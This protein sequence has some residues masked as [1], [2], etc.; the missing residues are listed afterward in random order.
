MKH[1]LASFLG[2][3]LGLFLFALALLV[4]HRTLGEFRYHDIAR[5]LSSIPPWHIWMAILLTILNYAILTGYDILALKYIRR[6][7]ETGKTI[8][9]SFISYAFSQSLGFG[10]LT[11]GSLRFRLYSA[12][13]LSALEITSIVTFC[14]LTFWIG[15]LT[16]GGILFLIENFTL[17][18]DLHLPFNSIYPIGL[19]FLSLTLSYLIWSIFGKKPL[20]IRQWEFAVP[21]LRISFLQIAIA[22]TDWAVAGAVL[23]ALLPSSA[24]V[25]YP[26]LLGIFILAQVIGLISH[27]PGGL[28]IFEA[29]ILTALSPSIP[30]STIMASL[31]AYRIIYYLMPL[32]IGT[33]ALGT[34]EFL[35]TR[36]GPRGITFVAERLLPATMPV[37]LGISTFIGGIILLISGATPSLGHRLIFLRE[38]IPLPIIEFSHFLGSLIG[39]GLLFLAWGVHR[40]IDAAYRAT[41]VLLVAGATASLLKGGDYEEAFILGMMFFAF[42]PCAKHFHRRSALFDRPLSFS[43]IAAIA[44]TIIGS[45]W[46][47]FFSY[48]HVDYSNDL[49]WKFALHGDAPRFLRASI[50]VV[51]LAMAISLLRLL[52]PVA[53]VAIRTSI[54]ELDRVNDVVK[55]SPYT[56]AH[57][58]N[59]GDK[60]FLFSDSGKAFIMYGVEGRSWVALGDPIGLQSDWGDLIWRFRDLCDPYDGWP[61]FYQVKADTLYR[62]MDLG[63]TMQKLGEEARVA[64]R[65]F[66]LDKLKKTLRHSHRRVEKEGGTFEILQPPINPS[67]M[68]R[69]KSISDSWLSEKNTHEKGFSLGFFNE[70]YLEKYPIAIVRHEGAIVAF[71]NVWMG[72]GKHE[73]SIDLMR[74]QPDA[75]S[76]LIDFLFISLMQWGKN[77]GYSWFNLGM[78]PLSGLEQRA[79]APL[80]NRMGALLYRT[81]EHF[82]NFQGLRAYKEKFNPV[83]EPRYLVSPGGLVL[84]RIL[85]NI[86]TLISGGLKGVVSK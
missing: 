65:S 60:R 21:S 19:L 11:G 24:A 85:A 80:W 49:W 72:A 75:L 82:Y 17:P 46:I 81:G 28:G 16:V 51:G 48:K 13:G 34:Y 9:T 31:L 69:L 52:K 10:V 44:V 39:T 12:W 74:H 25:S 68:A 77:E 62:Y 40:R 29:L 42:L 56:Y 53:P 1:K 63:F 14:A 15:I 41:L 79:V 26:N 50:G 61:I 78:A 37:I 73:L 45:I 7:L 71:A 67:V 83:W 4:L 22:S 36:W 54:D 33:T 18:T 70:N 5:E 23:Y 84:P 2:P 8:L 58:A 76:G 38:F 27:V 3:L 30:A 20:R 57:L 6:K 59:I 32:A 55:T 66:E 35:R 64:L 86:A 43:W 47:G